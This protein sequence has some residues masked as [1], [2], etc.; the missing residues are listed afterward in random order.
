MRFVV[1]YGEPGGDTT[2]PGKTQAYSQTIAPTS[3][4]S[5]TLCQK[6]LRSNSPSLP[7]SPVA[8]A[9]TTIDWASIILPI[10]PPVVLAEAIRISLSPSFRAVIFWRLPKSTLL[11]V[12]E[13]VSATP[14][15]PSI[16][17]NTGYNHGPVRVK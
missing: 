11:D 5:A 7:P 12:S 17:P 3:R 6:I 14:S 8:A 16:V 4:A 10:T 9:A 15:Q 2:A 13:P 1:R